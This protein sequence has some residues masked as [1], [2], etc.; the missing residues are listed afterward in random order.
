MSNLRKFFVDSIDMMICVSLDENT[1]PRGVLSILSYSQI[2]EPVP[3]SSTFKT[4][5]KMTFIEH[6]L[7]FN[8]NYHIFDQQVKCHTLGIFGGGSWGPFSK[9]I[10]IF[11]C[12]CPNR[13]GVGAIDNPD[14]FEQV[15]D[16]YYILEVPEK[17]FTHDISIVR[18][19]KMF[20]FGVLEAFISK[21]T[22]YN[23]LLKET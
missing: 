5:W 17:N 18:C 19:Q 7:N 21:F 3:S 16:P 12:K 14:R 20:T 23:R 4:W 1:S 9:V 13:S 11:A 2:S 8:Q 15:F 22:Y 10:N 6:L